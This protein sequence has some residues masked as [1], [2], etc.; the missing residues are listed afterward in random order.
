MSENQIEMIKSKLF[1]TYE[2]LPNLS[3]HEV[4]EFLRSQIYII[5]RKAKLNNRVLIACFNE[6]L[7]DIEKRME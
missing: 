1:E 3:N 7:K 6:I 4:M 5:L 2:D